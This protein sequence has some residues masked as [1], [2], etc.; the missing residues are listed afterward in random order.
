MSVT[1]DTQHIHASTCVAHKRI[2]ML[3][4]CRATDTKQRRKIGGIALT[5]KTTCSL[6]L[7]SDGHCEAGG[8]EPVKGGQL[9]VRMLQATRVASFKGSG[10]GPD[11]RW[12]LV[13][14]ENGRRLKGYEISA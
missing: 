8:H 14:S 4:G 1:S 11:E 5:A 13:T 3:A 7:K 12:P 10:V 2:E 6:Q 9:D